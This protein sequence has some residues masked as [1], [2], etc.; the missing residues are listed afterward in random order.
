TQVIYITPLS[1]TY[2]FSAVSDS[3][4]EIEEAVEGNN[5]ASFRVHR[6]ADPAIGVNPITFQTTLGATL[7]NSSGAN[8][9]RVN[10]TLFNNII[11]LFPT[12]S[13]PVTVH[14]LR[15]VD[16]GE[17]VEVDSQAFASIAPGGLGT[18]V[19]FTTSGLAGDNRFRVS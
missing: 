8:N 6:Q 11:S 4:E 10:F 7:L 15:S 13:G 2:T 5:S 3:L 9:V 1:G 12:A 16:D 14:L 18:A 19:Q 17:F